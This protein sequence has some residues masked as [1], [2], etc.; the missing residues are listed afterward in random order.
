VIA[1]AIA[2]TAAASSDTSI[3][4]RRSK[5]S[6]SVPVS[7]VATPSAPIAAKRAADIHAVECV[8]A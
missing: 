2:T 8:D 1:I 3:T 5:R 6:P 7:E 4:R